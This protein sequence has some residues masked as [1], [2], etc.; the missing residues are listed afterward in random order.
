MIEE[1]AGV[2]KHRRRKERAE[3][4]LATTQ[5]NLE[6]LGDLV[7]EVRRQMRPLERQAAAARSHAELA[8]E[9]AAVRRF[10]YGQ[11]LVQLT[12]RETELA[13]ALRTFE[14]DVRELRQR[15]R[16]LDAQATSAAAELSSRREEELAAALGELQGLQGRVRG[17]LG[18]LAERR[19]GVEAALDASAD[20]N[21][22]ASLE[23]DAS[24]LATELRRS[25]CDESRSTSSAPSCTSLRTRSRAQRSEF[26]ATWGS[27]DAGRRGRAFDRA[28]RAPRAL[29]ERSLEARRARR[30]RGSLERRDRTAPGAATS[31]CA[32]RA[33]P[34]RAHGG[35]GAP[36]P[37]RARGDATSRRRRRRAAP[38]PSRA[39][40]DLA[41][42]PGR[43]R[44]QPGPGRGARA[45]PSDLTGAGGRDAHRRPRRRARRA[46][47]PGR[48]RRGLR[49]R[50]RGGDRRLARGGRRRTTGPTARRALERLRREGAAGWC[51]PRSPVASHAGVVARGAT[52]LRD[53][54]RPRA[55]RR[56]GRRARARPTARGGL[57]RRRPSTR[58]STSRSR[59][60]TSSS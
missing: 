29:L 26:E 36:R 56:R 33:M 8:A 41:R 42:A 53:V 45:R 46:R 28:S 3:R 60:P 17:T 12:T 58:P 23:A 7:R 4:R 27:G 49:A 21:V 35:R 32:P 30:T 16:A 59:G 13:T 14:V 39:R 19:R 10:L 55:R 52:A 51:C 20:E 40:G 15:T 44:A 43:R 24:K 18:V 48:R 38:P 25:P 9:L 57:L 50:R 47:G 11:E 1:A 5:E 34:R 31:S 2:L 37:A 6:R 22:V 54:V